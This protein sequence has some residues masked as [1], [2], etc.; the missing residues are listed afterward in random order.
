MNFKTTPATAEV[1]RIFEE[2]CT[3]PHPSGHEAQLA[4]HIGAEA[5]KRGLSVRQDEQGNLRID[6]PADSGMETAP[7]VIFQAHLD[8][9]PQAAAGVKFDFTTEAIRLREENGWIRAASATTLGSDDG[10]GVAAA[11]ALLFDRETPRGPLSA[12]FTVQEETGLTGAESLE[13]AFLEGEYLLNLDSEEEGIFYIGCAGGARLEAHYRFASEAVPQGWTF[14]SVA[15]RNLKGGHSGCNIADRRGN[16]VQFLARFLRECGALCRIVRVEGGSLDNVIPRESVAVLA[17][18]PELMPRLQ[19][20]AEE[21]AHKLAREFEAPIDF[22]IDVEPVSTL[23]AVWP[24]D[25][26]GRLL[27]AV[28][29]C[30][31]GVIAWDKTFE[32]VRSSSNLAAWH[33]DGESLVVR[34]SQRSLDN[35]ERD[36]LT[37]AVGNVLQRAGGEI[38][39]SCVYSGWTP[40]PEAPLAHVARKV[41]LNCF[42]TEPQIKVIHAGLECGILSGKSPNLQMLSLGPTLVDPHSPAEKLEIASVEKFYHFL[43]K[44]TEELQKSQK[45][46]K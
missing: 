17:V 2:L 45:N 13:G 23:E 20:I 34:T 21:F 4:A 41:Y 24:E 33:S 30:P 32:V 29:D 40:Q 11:L 12:V 7:R 18:A 35:D 25:F 15:V 28:S 8:M 6:R 46:S 3:I 43:Q 37:R 36:A 9:V 19:R 14:A 26:Q 10:I 22:G 42:G 27:E 38:R 1:W 5:E 16:A 39:V 44:I 31:N